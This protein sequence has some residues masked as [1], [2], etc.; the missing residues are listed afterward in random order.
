V[1]TFQQTVQGFLQ[2]GLLL[3]QVV[4]LEK[5]GVPCSVIIAIVSPAVQSGG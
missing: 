1:I 2:A 5:D 4:L 3:G